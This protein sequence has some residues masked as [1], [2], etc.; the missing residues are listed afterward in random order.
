MRVATRSFLGVVLLVS[1][2]GLMCGSD[3]ADDSADGGSGG[4]GGRINVGP[5]TGTGCGAACIPFEVGAG[6]PRPFDLSNHENAGVMIDPSGALVLNPA[7]TGI[8]DIIWIANTGQGTVTKVDTKTYK[9]LGRYAIG[10]PVG[11]V[12]L[13]PSR[14]SVNSD[15]DVF[16]GNRAGGRL[17]KISS[18]GTKCPDTNKDGK[19]TTSS[20]LNDV[21]PW[22]QDDCVL[23]EVP[24]PGETLVRGV[25]AQDLETP[26]PVPDDP[27]RSNIDHWVWAG[28]TTG[29][30]VRKFDGATGA[31][32]ISTAAPTTIYGLALDG[33]GQLYMSGNTD[34]EPM[35][36]RVDTTRCKDQ[37][38]CDAAEI[39][40]STCDALGACVC[41]SCATSTCDNAV[42]ERIVIPDAVYGITVDYKQ[43]VWLGGAGV[44]R[45]DRSAPANARYAKVTDDFFHGIAADAKGWVWA[46]N[47][48][49]SVRRV[50]GDSLAWTDVADIPSKGMAVD[51]D[52][53]IWAIS[54]NSG[55]SV[56]VPGPAITDN[57][58]QAPAGANPE[59]GG[60]D[61]PVALGYCYTYSDMTGQQ[62]ALVVGKPGY[63]R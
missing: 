32:L 33:K 52:G 15:G 55:A 17:L 46:A 6:T 14:T 24:V 63:Y 38:S 42:K 11:G 35:F 26:T 36:G 58:V 19:I 28:G 51:R 41:T 59:L 60:A 10:V 49:T 20:G 45:Y 61:P 27:F 21:L 12:T 54:Y 29:R 13:D 62:L 25:A 16:L 48:A 8:P 57:P 30:T 22:G 7:S 1:V 50:N 47:G 31:L 53:K 43:R 56:I 5:G 39:C 23:W 34:T 37:A 40:V 18:A 4:D 44:K 2:G 9:V 3:G